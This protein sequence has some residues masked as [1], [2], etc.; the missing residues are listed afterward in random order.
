VGFYWTVE[1]YL[2]AI[3]FVSIDLTPNAKNDLSGSGLYSEQD[4]KKGYFLKLTPPNAAK[5]SC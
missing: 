3:N 2:Y 5:E 1:K 4:Q